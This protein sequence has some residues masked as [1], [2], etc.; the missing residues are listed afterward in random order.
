MVN[1]EQATADWWKHWWQQ[2]F[3]WSGLE[4]F[5]AWQ[6]WIVPA[7][8]QLTKDPECFILTDN[9][10][11]KGRPDGARPANLKDYWHRCFEDL[12]IDANAVLLTSPQ[13][14][15]QFTPL[16]APPVWEDG[17]PVERTA[18]QLE[19]VGQ[20]I[21]WAISRSKTCEWSDKDDLIGP[22]HRAQLQ[23]IVFQDFCTTN[24]DPL[25]WHAYSA[26]FT[27]KTD[28]RNAEFGEI[29]QFDQACFT[30]AVEFSNT[31]F[32]RY[33]DFEA[34]IFCNDTNFENALFQDT[35]DFFQSKFLGLANFH[36]AK[37]NA[38]ADFEEIECA[39]A[40]NF[41]GAEFRG[42]VW[43]DEMDTI[44]GAV[45]TDDAKS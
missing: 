35:A 12:Q 42:A 2:D 22:D 31:R 17:T 38:L 4:A 1:A 5:H 18:E 6:G 3:S 8:G 15:K 37:F 39:D 26:C 32:R 21:N 25:Y 9:R 16:H 28:F 19:L 36:S 10:R 34:A 43:F 14:G 20:M 24:S 40:P 33:A 7:D 13:S 41:N 11:Q 45:L 29:A 23:G 44:N 27:G 30:G